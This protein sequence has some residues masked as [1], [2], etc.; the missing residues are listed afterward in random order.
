MRSCMKPNSTLNRLPPDPNRPSRLSTNPR[1]IAVNARD[2][3][4][5]RTD[6]PEHAAEPLQPDGSSCV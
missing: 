1:T 2:K 3:L 6:R 4:G 5:V